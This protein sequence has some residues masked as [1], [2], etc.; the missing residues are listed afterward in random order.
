M[1][2]KYIKL[3]V[4]SICLA[5]AVIVTVRHKKDLIINYF[6]RPT[7]F[8]RLYPDWEHNRTDYTLHK[9]KGKN[10][11]Q[12]NIKRF[13]KNPDNKVLAIASDQKDPFLKKLK[14][15]FA[16]PHAHYISGTSKK[17]SIPT[18]KFVDHD[19]KP[20]PFA[21]CQLFLRHN[22]W[23]AEHKPYKPLLK[24]TLDENGTTCHSDDSDYYFTRKITFSHPDHNDTTFYAPARNDQ[25]SHT[26]YVCQKDFNSLNTP[27]T[28]SDK[29]HRSYNA[30]P[31]SP[32]RI[33][34]RTRKKSTW[35]FLNGLGEPIPFGSFTLH[36]I[37]T[38]KPNEKPQLIDTIKLDDK[39][40]CPGPV[41][42]S[43][44]YDYIID[45]NHPYY[46]KYH[47]ELLFIST[48]N[49]HITR[50]PKLHQNHPHFDRS[51]RAQVFDHNDNPIPDARVTADYIQLADHSYIHTPGCKDYAV[52]TDSNGFFDIYMPTEK[53][54][55]FKGPVPLGAKI[56][57]SLLT[58]NT[59]VPQLAWGHLPNGKVH[60]IKLAKGVLQKFEFEN[61]D[62]IITDPNILNKMHLDFHDQCGDMRVKYN[63]FKNGLLLPPYKLKIDADIEYSRKY[64]ALPYNP[65]DSSTI[66]CSAKTAK[67]PDYLYKV[68]VLY[69]DSKKTAKNAIVLI[70]N[71]SPHQS[72]TFAEISEKQWKHFAALNFPII[73]NSET[74]KKLDSNNSF[75][76][77]TK[78]EPLNE[79]ENTI[80]PF[81][82]ACAFE[83]A[84][85]TDANGCFEKHCGKYQKIVVAKQNYLTTQTTINSGWLCDENDD[86][87]I[88]IETIPLYPAAKVVF[89]PNLP[90]Y[91]FRARPN[92]IFDLNDSPDC[93]E[94]KYA[95]SNTDQNNTPQNNNTGVKLFTAFLYEAV[96]NQTPYSS[97]PTEDESQTLPSPQ[98]LNYTGAETFFYYR[99]DLR[100]NKR[101]AIEVP[102]NIDFKLQIEPTV[103]QQFQWATFTYEKTLNLKQGESI[104]LPPCQI[105]AAPKLNIKV[106]DQNSKPLEGIIV[107]RWF[108]DCFDKPITAYTDAQGRT[109]FY[110][111]YNTKGLVVI[112]D[113]YNKNLRVTKD[114]TIGPKNNPIEMIT[115]TIPKKILQ[116]IRKKSE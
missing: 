3:A 110:V 100:Q 11:A 95:N 106:I 8:I 93:W 109:D 111:N 90:T 78:K 77:H 4:I 57:Y 2:K 79:Y 29:T 76:K 114:Y 48:G 18:W 1:I 105:E 108:R 31:T 72:K 47:Y 24:F 75:F 13:T 115:I 81:Y 86:G 80:L 113:I 112:G 74:K 89:Q 62:G 19:N 82:Q 45:Y 30:P 16:K 37:S 6:N 32:F 64:K 101:Q 51:L 96:H 55:K 44:F 91:N 38:S 49:L 21:D 85:L 20:I 46:G 53:N 7:L 68:N 65:T 73:I 103:Y 92:Y 97:L 26:F 42:A 41:S 36:T 33:N 9:V 14:T 60:T 28:L 71:T 40:S 87:I 66:I 69:A 22:N 34:P 25:K 35:S 23:S 61:Q 104:E 83:N 88:E 63:D 54:D 102:A 27:N 17:K 12:F 84:F 52:T 67:K 98:R 99:T 39:G 94:L 107:Q 70:A 56:K 15:T 58:T 59:I 116:Q 5:A 43:P 50:I 10:H